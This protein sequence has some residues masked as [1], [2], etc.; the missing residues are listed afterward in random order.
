MKRFLATAI[1]SF[2]AFQPTVS[3]AELTR[4]EARQLAYAGDFT[5]LERRLSQE[6]E[7]PLVESE[8]FFKLR[9]LMS[10]FEASDPRMVSF[11][12]SW[13]DAVPMSSFAHSAR[14]FSLSRGAWDIR[15]ERYAKYVHPQALAVHHNMIQQAIAHA[16]RALELDADFIPASDALLNQSA[17]SRDK[18]EILETLDRVMT[19]QPNW[20]SLRRSLDMAHQ[21]YG[22]TAAM[23]EQL[24]QT[25]A[26]LIPSD[27]PDMLFRCRYSGLKR[28]YFSESYDL[29]QTMQAAVAK[30]PEFDLSR[31]IRMTDRSESHNRTEAEI[32]F[33]RKT[34]LEQAW[35]R[36]RVVQNF[37]M[38][39]KTRLG[40]RSLEEEIAV[41]K[42]DEVKEGLR[43]DPFDQ[44]LMKL[45]E[46]WIWYQIK[47]RSTE[48][49]PAALYDLQEQVAE[50]FA[51]RRLIASPFSGQNWEQVAKL[52]FGNDSPLNIFLGD[53]FLVNGIVY[54]GFEDQA[55]YRFMARKAEQW[56]R[57]RGVVRLV[58]HKGARPEKGDAP[59]WDRSALLHCPFL[60]AYLLLE[61]VCAENGGR[62]YCAEE[63]FASFAP[64]LEM[65]RADQNC[66]YL[67]GLSPEELA[68]K[69]VKVDLSY[70]PQDHWP[71]V[72]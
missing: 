14:S 44:S 22:G 2:L 41:L 46:N 56:Y 39:F 3:A 19:Q 64:Q 29:R 63:D 12:E 16:R 66:D 27:G 15:G 33:A 8:D 10:V 35:W 54:S 5:S 38:A 68:F 24:C 7:R 49:A 6:R 32:E 60:R 71:A 72:E 67:N 4:S 65:A 43:H 47:N 50:D 58:D 59:H 13:V 45:A 20:G 34:I 11:V 9:R 21:G 40:G 62:G 61:Q 37:D 53:Q 1:L 18:S 70:D 52:K 23:L 36:P 26:P 48:Y 51:F 28:Y 55:L 30:D 17:T 57:F 42:I 25:Y 69:P 31:A